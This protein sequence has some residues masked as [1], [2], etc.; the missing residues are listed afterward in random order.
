MKEIKAYVRSNMANL[1]LE[2]LARSDLLDSSIVAVRGVT[3][4]LP[5]EAYSFS[6]KLGEV[7]QEVIKLELVCKD[8][9][10]NR[11]AEVIQKAACT[12]RKGDGMIFIA[13]IDEAIRISSGEP[14]SRSSS[15]SA[16]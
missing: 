13:P 2:A 4:G 6:M 16:L 15:R 12:G 8:E 1:V 11:L 7:F 10:A 3:K 5:Q 9:N 14:A